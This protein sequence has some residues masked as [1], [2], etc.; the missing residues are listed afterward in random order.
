MARGKKHTL[1]PEYSDDRSQKSRSK[2][3]EKQFLQSLSRA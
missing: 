1:F 2:E 3:P